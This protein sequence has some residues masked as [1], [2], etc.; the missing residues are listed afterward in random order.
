M[1]SKSEGRVEYKIY[2]FDSFFFLISTM[3]VILVSRKKRSERV[4]M[5]NGR[6]VLTF[7]NPN[8]NV[9]SSNIEATEEHHRPSI[10]RK[11]RFD[12]SHVSC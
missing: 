8:Y 7:S 10:W 9:S 1:N 11:L 4:Y 5:Y 2:I 6:S 12:R 3:M